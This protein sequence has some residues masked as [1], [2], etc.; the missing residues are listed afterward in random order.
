MR[1]KSA[2]VLYESKVFEGVCH[3]DI[4]R[5]MVNNKVCPKPFMMRAVEGF[6]T[7]CGM[8]VDRMTALA[9]ALEAGQVTEREMRGRAE[10]HSA[11]L[12]YSE[13]RKGTT[14]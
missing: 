1:I 9:I 3:C 7:E 8:F 6:V 11:D 14:T 5:A 2:A 13:T 4:W 10:L 12:R